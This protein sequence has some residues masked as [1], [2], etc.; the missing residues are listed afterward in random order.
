M[1]PF[2]NQQRSTPGLCISYPESVELFRRIQSQDSRT[3]FYT[4]RPMGDE[5]WNMVDGEKTVGEIV[6]AVM[7]EFGI[8][9]DPELFLPV[10]KGFEEKGLIHFEKDR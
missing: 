10:F 2:K 7:M 6:S 5:A 9:A 1:V 3:V 8:M 4:I